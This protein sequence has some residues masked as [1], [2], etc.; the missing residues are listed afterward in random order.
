ELVRG[1]R[2]ADGPDRRFRF[3]HLLVRDAAYARLTKRRR[4]DLHERYADWLD[5]DPTAAADET[6]AAHL[7]QAYRYLVELNPRDPRA[8][9]VARRAVERLVRAAS[10][11][12][13]SGSPDTGAVLLERALRLLPARDPVRLRYV[14]D[15]ATARLWAGDFDI[16]HEH[17]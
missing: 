14:A 12:Q 17:I 3:K 16:A 5:A 9:R 6:V 1:D 7:E 11:V 13:I 8:D 4:I 2:A 10:A 15:A